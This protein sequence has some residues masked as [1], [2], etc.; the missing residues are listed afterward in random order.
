MSITRHDCY[1]G[2]L[3]LL[4]A[5]QGRP[6]IIGDDQQ[7]AGLIAKQARVGRCTRALWYRR[8]PAIT[9]HA[10]AAALLTLSAPEGFEAPAI[11]TLNRLVSSCRASMPRTALP[12]T[13][14]AWRPSVL[15]SDP[16]H[17]AAPADHA[18]ALQVLGQLSRN[19]EYEP[20][21]DF[22]I[23]HYRRA[24]RRSRRSHSEGREIHLVNEV[25]GPERYL[26]L[27]EHDANAAAA[28]LHALQ[29]VI[30][31]FPDIIRLRLLLDL[32]AADPY[33]ESVSSYTYRRHTSLL[34]RIR[35]WLP[36]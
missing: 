23:G 35:A 20:V 15:T 31:E 30:S 28:T 21:L 6:A 7:L 32:R 10:Y 27:T 25:G 26:Y 9:A 12:T 22:M 19:P 4:H 18:A 29:P 8:H 14:A 36:W 13:L 17:S 1:P 24:L 5:A 3:R 33:R 11:E 16:R 34:D 2:C